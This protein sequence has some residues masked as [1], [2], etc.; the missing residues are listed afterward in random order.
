[1]CMKKNAIRICTVTIQ[2]MGSA[3]EK[4]RYILTSHTG[5]APAQNDL[6]IYQLSSM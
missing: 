1:M 6:C 2:G 4:Q 5:Q 3:N